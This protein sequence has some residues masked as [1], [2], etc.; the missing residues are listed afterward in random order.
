VAIASEPSRITSGSPQPQYEVSPIA[1][2]LQN[3]ETPSKGFAYL[4]LTSNRDADKK[5]GHLEITISHVTGEAIGISETSSISLVVPSD[6]LSSQELSL[7]ALEADSAST[8]S[9]TVTGTSTL[10]FQLRPGKTIS[11]TATQPVV[12]GLSNMLASSGQP[13][14]RA[15]A[16]QWKGLLNIKDNTRSIQIS[17]E[18]VPQSL[19]AAN[20]SCAWINR[21]EYDDNHENIYTTPT[22]ITTDAPGI[23]NRIILRMLNTSAEPLANDKAEF[24]VTFPTDDDN[25]DPRSA[26]CTP[27]QL[28][29]ILC[30]AYEQADSA[31][32]VKEEREGKAKYWVLTPPPGRE[33]IF[34]PTNL[35]HF[36]FSNLVTQMPHGTALAQIHWRG[37]K[38]RNPGYALVPITKT[39]PKPYVR[40]FSASVNGKPLKSGDQVPFKCK[41]VLEWGLF[42]ADACTISGV[43]GKLGIN[44]SREVIPALENNAYVITPMV[45]LDGSAKSG[46][47]RSFE[48]KVGPPTVSLRAE[49]TTLGPGQKAKLHW[50]STNGDCFLRGPGLQ[51]QPVASSGSLEVGPQWPV[52]QHEIECVGIRT[53]TSAALIQ[54]PV[55][56]I[57]VASQILGGKLRFTWRTENA[58]QCTVECYDLYKTQRWNSSGELSGTTIDLDSLTMFCEVNAWG[59]GRAQL[60]MI[61][62][63]DAKPEFRL[64]ET[65][66]LGKSTTLVTWE[67]TDAETCWIQCIDCSAGG[68]PL[69][70]RDDLQGEIERS[71][72]GTSL[73][74]RDALKG[75]IEWDFQDAPRGYRI[76]MDKIAGDPIGRCMGGFLSSS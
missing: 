45:T 75:E 35:V 31:W 30:R 38:G 28:G 4:Y 71:V 8:W 47:F 42:A 23:S 43:D 27:Q 24:V 59:N 73:W 61:G 67:A 37:I 12:I 39:D 7:I 26:V 9:L 29:P 10:S 32:T 19:S 3:K 57:F 48:F 69:W 1:F 60:L 41:L 22:T 14:N 18:F 2:S 58:D 66:F 17:R 56:Q 34:G 76:F 33:K 44:G 52:A 36:E 68:T 16:F 11:I 65:K 21:T 74:T 63:P 6:L 5:W 25:G 62:R 54:V 49:P 64:R 40:I 46:P 50:E 55:C 51:R 15:V 72:G 70:T 13:V 53:A 20:I